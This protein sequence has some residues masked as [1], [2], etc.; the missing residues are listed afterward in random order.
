VDLIS[1]SFLEDNLT[2]LA[3]ALVVAAVAA[4]GPAISRGTPHAI[5][6][7]RRSGS[8][9]AGCLSRGVAGRQHFAKYP[10]SIGI[11]SRNE[12]AAADYHAG[13]PAIASLSV[14]FRSA[15]GGAGSGHKLEQ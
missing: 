3:Y 11:S 7:D 2:Y 6:H 5:N 1:I 12:P 10:A 4:A 13:P 8:I 15:A 9:F 14:P